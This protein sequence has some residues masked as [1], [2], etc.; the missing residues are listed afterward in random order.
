MTLWGLDEGA[1]QHAATLGNEARILALAV[2]P[3]RVADRENAAIV[4]QQ[5][6]AQMAPWPESALMVSL[7]PPPDA[8]PDT[9]PPLCLCR[10]WTEW[11]ATGKLDFD[12]NAQELRGE[13]AS[14]GSGSASTGSEYGGVLFRPQL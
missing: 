10:K 5:A 8:L 13:E 1:K 6:F 9:P 7:G 3:A 14:A 4:Y 2:A 12:L 11:Q